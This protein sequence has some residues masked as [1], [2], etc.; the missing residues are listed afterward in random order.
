MISRSQLY[1]CSGR[2]RSFQK[3]EVF[4]DPIIGQ[5]TAAVC[6]FSPME[7]TVLP[8]LQVGGSCLIPFRQS[9]PGYLKSPP[10]A[11][12][13][14]SSDSIWNRLEITHVTS[15]FPFY[16]EKFFC[17]EWYLQLFSAGDA[18]ALNIHCCGPKERV[19]AWP[20]KPCPWISL[21]RAVENC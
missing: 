6:Q 11:I 19:C 2:P 20:S 4:F 14:D 18:N 17:Q 1:N 16:Q 21:R 15:S 8:A 12:W 10:F 9:Q 3:W 7:G 13:T 5:N